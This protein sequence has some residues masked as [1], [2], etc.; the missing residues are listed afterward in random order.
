MV[1]TCAGKNVCITA[2]ISSKA[3]DCH[4]LQDCYFSLS[5]TELVF[6]FHSCISSE[7]WGSE[8]SLLGRLQCVL[9]CQN[10]GIRTRKQNKLGKTIWPACIL[11]KWVP[12][13]VEV[14]LIERLHISLMWGRNLLPVCACIATLISLREGLWDAAGK[15]L[16]VRDSLLGTACA[17]RASLGV[18]APGNEMFGTPL[19]FLL[20]TV[21]LPVSYSFPSQISPLIAKF[22]GWKF[23]IYLSFH[24]FFFLSRQ[25]FK[26]EKL[27]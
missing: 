8:A 17:P 3:L 16:F 21:C 15:E 2:Y 6:W 25:L 13:F 4:R 9:F 5:P 10:G 11:F 26:G 20:S 18:A 22:D 19:C 27:F 23:L 12:A 24:F 1:Q 14:P 7:S